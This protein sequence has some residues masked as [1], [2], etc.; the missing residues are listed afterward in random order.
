MT[1]TNLKQPKKKFTKS[2]RKVKP[3]EKKKKANYMVGYLR[4]YEGEKGTKEEKGKGRKETHRDS[5]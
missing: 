5:T 1:T 4:A 3:K 2:K